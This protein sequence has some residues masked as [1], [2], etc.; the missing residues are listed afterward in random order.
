MT[1]A[2]KTL[3]ITPNVKVIPAVNLPW[4]GEIVTYENY[5]HESR[6]FEKRRILGELKENNVD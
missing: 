2:S 3:S 1:T 6:Q 4:P 5:N